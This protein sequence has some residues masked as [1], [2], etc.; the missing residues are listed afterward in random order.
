M[1]TVRGLF[2]AQISK[3]NLF[4]K[5][6]NGFQQKAPSQM[7][8][9][10]L[11]MPLTQKLRILNKIT[12]TTE[13]GSTMLH[14]LFLLDMYMFNELVIKNDL[15][16]KVTS[17]FVFMQGGQLSHDQVLVLEEDRHFHCK[18]LNRLYRN[19]KF[20]ILTNFNLVLP[21]S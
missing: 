2:R 13:N 19:S 5:R 16:K 11:H 1:V 18:V 6:L 8:E 21:T 3:V 10:V 15:V 7:F 14:N 4:L 17:F 9:K 12:L 20:N